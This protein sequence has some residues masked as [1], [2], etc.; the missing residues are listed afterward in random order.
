MLLTLQKWYE[1]NKVS[2][3]I[4]SF[5]TAEQYAIFFM[6]FNTLIWIVD[7]NHILHRPIYITQI[8]DISAILKQGVFSA[9]SSLDNLVLW[10]KSLADFVDSAWITLA[11]NDYFVIT[12]H[13]LEEGRK[14]WSL[15]NFEADSQLVFLINQGSI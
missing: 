5:E 1:I 13:T 14:A 6:I 2:I 7:I 9:K 10:V 11:E 12:G 8:L 3:S 15:E 4:I